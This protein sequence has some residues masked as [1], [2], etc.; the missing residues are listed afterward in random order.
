[1]FNQRINALFL[2]LISSCFSTSIYAYNL[3]PISHLNEL[4]KEYINKTIAV[5]KNDTLEVSLSPAANNLQVQRCEEAI[6]VSVPNQSSSSQINTLEMTCLGKVS[7]HIYVPVDVKILTNVLVAK[8]T[9]PGREIITQDMITTAKYDKNQLYSGFYTDPKDIEG[10]V[11]INSITSGTVL[12]K[13]NI[14]S[15]ILINRNQT[16]SIINRHGGIMVK[17][18]GIAKSS[19]ALND[20]IKVMNP[21]SKRTIDAVV[22]SG[23]SVEVRG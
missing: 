23:S 11:A 21:S 8:E 10:Q 3:E 19:G 4:A 2:L 20:V 18:E 6:Q 12:T 7:W 17:A 13:K 5:D 14:Q 9:I 15:P 16:V 1:M 22:V